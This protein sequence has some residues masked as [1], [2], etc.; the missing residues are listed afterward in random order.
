MDLS[1]SHLKKLKVKQLKELCSDNLLPTSGKKIEL[2]DRLFHFYTSF[3]IPPINDDNNLLNVL[4]DTDINHDITSTDSLQEEKEIERYNEINL[5]DLEFNESLKNDIFK[6]VIKF[7]E[8]NQLNKITHNQIVIYLEKKGIEFSPSSN[9]E[10]LIYL[11]HNNNFEAKSPESLI[12]NDNPQDIE[13]SIE[14]LR[15]ARLN[16]FN[17]NILNNN[18]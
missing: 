14:E 1:I 2:V 6:D 12:K 15:Y 17:K 3:D 16:F 5:Q 7:I 13:L 4:N 9:L 18:N 11:I 10:D 8:T